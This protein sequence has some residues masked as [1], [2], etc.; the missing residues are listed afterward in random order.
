MKSKDI[1]RAGLAGIMSLALAASA[2]AA[3]LDQIQ[4]Y[5]TE[6]EMVILHERDILKMPPAEL[7]KRLKQVV[8]FPDRLMA[9]LAKQGI[10]QANAKQAALKWSYEAGDSLGYIRYTIEE[11]MREPRIMPDLPWDK[12]VENIAETIRSNAEAAARVSSLNRAAKT[13]VNFVPSN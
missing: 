6:G 2:S 5:G 9:A 13:L 4:Y 3:A 10:A 7:E 8:T 12:Q 1:V 11:K